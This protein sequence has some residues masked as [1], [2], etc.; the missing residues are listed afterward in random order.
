[1]TTFA[2]LP[3]TST[4]RGFMPS[5]SL[6]PILDWTLTLI[7]QY[8][9]S[10]VLL[11]LI[12]NM[13]DNIAPG[14]NLNAFYNLVWNVDTA[15]GYGLDVWGRIVGIGRVLQ[16]SAPTS[17]FGFKE[18]TDAAGFNQ[19]PFSSGTALTSNFA[20]SDAAFRTL[21]LAKALANICDGSIK[22]INQILINLFAGLGNC[23]VTDGL[24]MTMTYT[25]S[26]P[27]TPVQL[28]IVSNSGVLPKPAGVSVTVVHP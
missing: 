28:A 5:L 27:L 11:Q 9:N 17:W 22:A 19:A 12:S 13:D 1:M 3:G 15:Q 14:A 20:L 6:E 26:F 2:P 7:S 21:I 18:A 4:S 23:Y 25:F 16:V 24:D 10:P 8:A